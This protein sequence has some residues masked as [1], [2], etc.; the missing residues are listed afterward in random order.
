MIAARNTAKD[1]ENGGVGGAS[2]SFVR[3][4]SLCHVVL[5]T[6][7]SALYRSTEQPTLQAGGPTPNQEPPK[8]SPEITE[9]T[10]DGMNNYHVFKHKEFKILIFSRQRY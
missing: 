9:E 5:F 2:L 10:T 8:E 3:L 4:V 6:K 7:H 1:Q